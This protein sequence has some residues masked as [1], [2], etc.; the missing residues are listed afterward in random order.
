MDVGDK[1]FAQYPKDGARMDSGQPMFEIIECRKVG[2]G[3]SFKTET[4]DPPFR[5]YDIQDV[6]V[7]G[8]KGANAY[9]I[10]GKIFVRETAIVPVRFFKVQIND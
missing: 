6:A 4:H 9:I 8:P 3:T 1:L 10:N 2:E 7:V 5:K